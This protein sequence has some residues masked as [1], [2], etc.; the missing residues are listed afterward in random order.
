M[1]EE[2]DKERIIERLLSLHERL[3]ELREVITGPAPG[4]DSPT[5]EDELGR[6]IEDILAG[7]ALGGVV[8]APEGY[9]GSEG[10]V[11]S[12]PSAHLIEAGYRMELSDAPILHVN[13]GFADLAHVLELLEAQVIPES[14]AAPLCRELLDFLVTPPELFPYESVY[15]DAYNSRER[16]LERRLGATAGWFPAGRTR[17]EAGRIAI[18]LGLREELVALL[19]E[20]IYLTRSLTTRAKE[21]GAVPWNDTTY[22]QPAQPSSFGYY[23]AGFAEQAVRDMRRIRNC[24][25]GVN[26]SPGGSGGVDGTS[27]PVDRMRMA[28]RLGFEEP[29]GHIRDGMWSTDIIIDCAIAA[30]QAAL[31]VDRLAED[32]EIF[33]SPQFG[34]VTLGGSSSRASVLLPQK[35]NPYA[36]AVIRGGCGTLIG[37]ATGLMVTQRTPSART[38]NWLYAG[39]E[40][41]RAVQLATRLVTLA[42]DVVKTMQVDTNALSA[43]AGDHFS[44]ATDLAERL[45]LDHDL[46][47]RSAYRIVGRAVANAVESGTERLETGDLERACRECG[48]DPAPSVSALGAVPDAESLLASRDVPGGSAST[49]LSA[50]YYKMGAKII[51]NMRWVEAIEERETVVRKDL[52]RRAR[53]LAEG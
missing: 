48:I 5:P 24:Y 46:D 50:H 25:R 3:E 23:L 40:V 33:S 15:G 13:L 21:L 11:G 1:T 4:V 37:R 43:S 26:K 19:R 47:Y 20:V 31:N 32:L 44:T 36:L 7:G 9:L 18:R 39:G 30:V 29:T 35:R 6:D 52:I 27:I 42:A 12:G 17:R 14:V 41:I 10:R 8:E 53:E 49:R 16:E 45:V 2:H 22:L 51:Q 34:Y 38:D 28:I